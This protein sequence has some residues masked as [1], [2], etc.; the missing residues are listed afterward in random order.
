MSAN[1]AD[2]RAALLEFIASQGTQKSAAAALG[3]SATYLVDLKRGRRGFSDVMLE[4]LGLRRVVI[5]RK[6][7]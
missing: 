5:D 2:P 4:K 7:S 3:V 6:A 1:P